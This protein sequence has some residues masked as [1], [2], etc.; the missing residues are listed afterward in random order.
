[1]WDSPRFNRTYPLK[2][3]RVSSLWRLGVSQDLRIRV[4]PHYAHIRDS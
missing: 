1:M 3:L 4:R 2:P